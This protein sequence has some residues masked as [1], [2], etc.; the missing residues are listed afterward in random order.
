MDIYKSFD[1]LSQG[2]AQLGE[3]WKEAA[4]DK[5]R[6]KSYS[7]I[8]DR[9]KNNNFFLNNERREV[10]RKL[11][12]MEK[13]YNPALIEK[14]R[15]ELLQEFSKVSESMIA[16]T[17]SEI[18]ELTEAR[19]AKVGEMLATPPTDAQNRLLAA[20][21]MRSNIDATELYSLFPAVFG[22]YQAMRVLQDIGKKNGVKIALPV[23]L[24][25]RALF[26]TIDKASDFLNGA[27]AEIAKQY[28][29]IDIKYRA[30][31]FVTDKDKGAQHD[32]A[33]KEIIAALDSVPQLQEVKAD[34]VQLTP[35]EK[36][37]IEHYFSDVAGLDTTDTANDIKV[38]KHTKAVMDAHPEEIELLKLSKY[39]SYVSEVEQAQAA[40]ESETA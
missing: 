2:I 6:E 12:D 20:L 3:R 36:A 27:C 22:N 10:N 21:Q 16:A 26:E 32:P 4:K 37:R 40:E 33:Y 29:D 30:F 39:A 8:A 25:P 28:K 1:A 11:D 35:T 9:M 5:D 24:E 17:R 7:G 15:G 18:K 13:L 14:K 31:Y 23:Q 19:K 34:K 38:L